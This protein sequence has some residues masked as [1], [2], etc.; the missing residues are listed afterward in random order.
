[1]NKNENISWMIHISEQQFWHTFEK[2]EVCMLL[3][4]GHVDSHD[5]YRFVYSSFAVTVVAVML[6]LLIWD[7]DCIKW[8]GKGEG[9]HIDHFLSNDYLSWHSLVHTKDNHE[10]PVIPA[11]ADNIWT[12][13]ISNTSHITETTCLVYL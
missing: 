7:D 11:A 1:M 12:G 4:S 2:T 8:S 5:S 13:H 6:S 3:L 10:K 9:E